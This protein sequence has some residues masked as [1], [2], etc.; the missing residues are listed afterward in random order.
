MPFPIFF[1]ALLD[2]LF[3]EW[4]GCAGFVFRCRVL[5]GEVGVLE[6]RREAY[7]LGEGVAFFEEVF[8]FGDGL[9]EQEL[10]VA[11]GLEDLFSTVR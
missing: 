6:G 2:L 3:V 5:S 11:E 4:F 10:F 7:V 9:G 8:D 1:D